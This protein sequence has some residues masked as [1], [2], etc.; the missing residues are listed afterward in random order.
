MGKIIALFIAIL[1]IATCEP[2]MAQKTFAVDND[3]TLDISVYAG[4]L[5]WVEFST[6]EISA[7]SK[8]DLRFGACA[9]WQIADSVLSLHTSTVY[10]RFGGE[11]MTINYFFFKAKTR[12]QKWSLEAGRMTTTATEVRPAP[13]TGDGQF[14]TW[15]QSR[16]PN[17][18]L[19]A[20]IGREFKFGTLK[21][22][23]AER[24]QIAEFSAHFAT[25]ISNHQFNLVGMIGGEDYQNF[26]L[27][28]V[29][30]VGGLYH[31]FVYKEECQEILQ[32][33][34][35]K[36]IGYFGAYTFGTSG[37]RL[38]LD[39]GYD[40]STEEIPRL[41]IGALKKFTGIVDGLIG[42][43]YNRKTDSINANLFVHL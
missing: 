22:G 20:K 9:N 26:S 17:S 6:E 38:Y 35:D 24:D 31:I 37:Y 2:T 30:K 13:G 7:A 41:E 12:N 34:P 21:F 29:H 28:L 18:A 8:Y 4:L 25:S 3:S 36:I 19:G 43:G 11:E 1:T 27:G 10:G 40:L 39:A 15:T 14:E 32:L 5:N 42:V 23:V 33:V 16:L